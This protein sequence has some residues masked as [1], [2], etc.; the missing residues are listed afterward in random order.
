MAKEFIGNLVFPERCVFG[1]LTCAKTQI[2]SINIM[3]DRPHKAADLILPGFINSHFHGLGASNVNDDKSSLLEIMKFSPKTGVT[4]ICPTLAAAPIEMTNVF[5]T[6]VKE[7][8][9]LSDGGAKMLGSHLE[10]PFIAEDHKGG[11]DA[12]YLRN[13][14]VKL[15]Q[16]L[17][18]RAD[19]TLKLMT[20]SPELPGAMEVVKLLKKNHVVVSV[21][22][23][24]A[25]P[26]VLEQAVDC[27][28]SLVCHLFDTF[29]E[30]SVECGVSQY[31]LADAVLVEDRVFVELILDGIHVPKGLL[32]LARRAAGVGR[33]VGITDSMVGTGLPDHDY[34]MADGRIFRLVNGD[35]C[36]LKSGRR[37]IVGSCL[38]MDQAFRNLVM[39]FGFS[40]SE[41]SQLL[42]TNPARVLQLENETGRLEKGL[43]ADITILSP[44]NYIVKECLVAGKTQYLAR[45]GEK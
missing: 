6:N 10:G 25:S 35:V 9:Q 11:M 13:P 31:S 33:L 5:L 2:A 4:G 18:D 1:V 38:T 19:G 3:D 21:G 43:R 7:L 12:E 39:K 16:Q 37:E 29:D 41:A 26:A 20:L 42:S 14:T 36:R 17:I 45:G 15:A 34:P 40:Y 30:R 32:E 28:V 44:E 24:G 8:S 23:T 22:H 27:G